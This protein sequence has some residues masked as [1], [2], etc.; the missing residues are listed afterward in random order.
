MAGNAYE[1][2]DA[3][4]GVPEINR[5]NATN[6]I[7]GD[8]EGNFSANFWTRSGYTPAGNADDVFLV[9]CSSAF[10]GTQ[11]VGTFS[12]REWNAHTATA[13][14]GT[15][16]NTQSNFA[17]FP[18]FRS[19]TN[20]A[21]DKLASGEL[22]YSVLGQDGYEVTNVRIDIV[23]VDSPI[24]GLTFDARLPDSASGFGS[25][26]LIAETS[27]YRVGLISTAYISDIPN[28]N[29]GTSGQ[30][31]STTG[32][33]YELIDAPSGGTSRTDAQINQLIDTRIPTAQRVPTG[34]ADGQILSRDG[35]S[36]LEWIDAPSGT[37]GNDSRIPA[38]TGQAGKIIEVNSA[39]TAFEYV[40]K[41]S[42]GSGG[43]TITEVYNS[44][45]VTWTSGPSNAI[46]T[47]LNI[48]SWPDTDDL[49]LYLFVGWNNKFLCRDNFCR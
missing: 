36:G 30:I 10:V 40:D 32:T 45:N 37:G 5:F 4:G 44:G 15:D 21:I 25:A 23:N 49:R 47:N 20:Y 28:P 7:S 24:S 34:G 38:T 39:G 48:T 6:N 42:G 1:L 35:T 31:L 2:I 16:L 17:T 3:M 22:V 27:G 11:Y 29:T 13:T 18:L 12:L 33:A 14:V 43:R 46:N 26:V 9:Q 19:S 41:P 8:E